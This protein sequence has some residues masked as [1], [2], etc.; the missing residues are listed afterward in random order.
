MAPFYVYAWGAWWAGLF[1]GWPA[2]AFIQ[3]VALVWLLF[4]FGHMVRA[5]V[6]H[7]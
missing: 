3:G 7:G 6:P 5:E 1:L 4:T 2:P